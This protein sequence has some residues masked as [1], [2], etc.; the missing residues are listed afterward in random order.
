MK[1][2]VLSRVNGEWL[3]IPEHGIVVVHPLEGSMS[4]CNT[5][6]MMQKSWLNEEDEGILW[7][8]GWHNNNS[9]AVAAMRSAHALSSDASL[10]CY[11]NWSYKT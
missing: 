4:W 2:T 1:V 8:R 7:I 3:L 5:E 11:V 10:E 9:V 6:G